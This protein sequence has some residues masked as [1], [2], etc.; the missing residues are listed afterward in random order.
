MS[1]ASE[2]IVDAAF[3]VYEQ[4]S[5]PIGATASL[6][7]DMLRKEGLDPIAIGS[8]LD[9]IDRY[10]P[11]IGRAFTV[12]GE[13]TTMGDHESL[14]EWTRMLSKTP[15]NSVLV[16]EPGDHDRSYMGELSANALSLRKVAAAVVDGPCRDSNQM[17]ALGFPVFSHGTTPRDIVGTW[18]AVEY[19]QPIKIMGYTITSDDLIIGDSDGLCV[20]HKDNYALLT[21]RLFEGFSS[22]NMVRDM[23]LR[24]HDPLDA[25]M[26]YRKF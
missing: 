26:R 14:I 23:I 17:R 19:G 10:T 24:G 18:Q 12:R 3:P 5:L 2:E 21:E 13:A 6:C 22:E 8:P 4:Y 15:G 7:F 1:V 20:T 11:F 25:Y 9:P 16:I